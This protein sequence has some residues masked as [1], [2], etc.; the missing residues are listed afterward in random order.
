MRFVRLNPQGFMK[1]GEW[2]EEMLYEILP[3][4]GAA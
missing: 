1:H 3:G 4:A 2:V